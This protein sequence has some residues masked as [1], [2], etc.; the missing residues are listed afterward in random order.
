MQDA[1][2][3]N[4]QSNRQI[5]NFLFL[6]LIFFSSI[7]SAQLNTDRILTIGKS[8]FYF[9]DYVLSIQYFNQVIKIKPYLAEPYMYRA[10]AKIQLG[11]YEGAEKDCNEAIERNPF[12]PQAY[13]TR[14]FARL[15]L[16]CFNEAAED[17]SKALEFSPDNLY[18]IANRILAFEK[19]G[20][21]E[22]ALKDIDEYL[23]LSPNNT[24]MYYEKGRLQLALK[25][26]IGAEKTFDKYIEMNPSNSLGWSARALLKLQRNDKEGA[27]KDYNEAIKRN[28]TFAGDYINR[29]FLNIEKNNFR[30]A[31]EDYNKAITLDS[32]NELAYFNRGLLRA[33]LGDTNNA[34]NDFEK[35]LTLNP[36]SPE[37]L[38]QKAILESTLGNYEEAIKNYQQLINNHPY[39][40]PAFLG[41]AEAYQKLGDEKNAFRYKQLAYNLETN[42][43]KIKK[44]QITAS[45]KIVQNTQN[46]GK[47]R[48]IEIFN[49]FI[50]QNASENETNS[51][52]NNSLRGTIQD[53]FVDIVNEPNFIL[54]YYSKPEEIRRTN[55]F[56]LAVEEYNLQKKLS[57]PLKITNHE[58]PLTPE[59]INQHFEKINSLS[60]QLGKN[61]QDA[62]LYFSRALEFSLIRDYTS[63]IEDLNKAISLRPN[64]MLAYFTRANIRYKLIESDNQ[65]NKSANTLTD[66]S[67]TSS[68]KIKEQQNKLDFE[69]ILRDYDKVIQLTPDFTFAYFNKANILCNQKDFSTAIIYY[70][71]VIELDRDFAEAYFNRGLSYLFLGEDNKG[72]NDLS[73]AGELGIYKSYNI[74][75]RFKQQSQE[76]K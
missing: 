41:I 39:F 22:A 50:T 45:A 56:H 3:M 38:W 68:N 58:I 24:D 60:F 62:D 72:L 25:D 59:L 11:D 13:Y 8:A 55:L 73:K 42:K 57:S 31:L 2:I 7:V 17:F 29:A 75:H 19:A 46:N 30:Q 67:E 16:N 34:L 35:V 36:S 32:K 5:K 28:S 69:L 71:K 66:G 63:A 48:N 49:R 54:T 26:T 53:K 18:L 44:E 15:K 27:L 40:L 10:M 20:N 65:L 74:I 64:F 12:I 43:D 47:Q 51:K 14:G 61:D 6:S 9:E 1:K 76:G 23:K 4:K 37:A 33:K 21:Y 52:Y 70:S